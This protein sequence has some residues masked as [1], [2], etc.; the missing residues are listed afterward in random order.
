MY[1][2]SIACFI[3]N[4][5]LNLYAHIVQGYQ[6]YHIVKLYLWNRSA[7]YKLSFIIYDSLFYLKYMNG[8]V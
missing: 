3:F 8:K 7:G 4:W 5:S 1:S 2:C 6:E